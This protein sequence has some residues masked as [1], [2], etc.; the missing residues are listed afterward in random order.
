[1]PGDATAPGDC[2]DG[3]SA[4]PL[5]FSPTEPLASV[6]E[7]SGAVAMKDAAAFIA[8]AMEVEATLPPTLR[9]EPDVAPATDAAAATLA[10]QGTLGGGD[11][12]P[13]GS[14][15]VTPA[16]FA[17]APV[18]DTPTTGPEPDGG[19]GGGGDLE[20]TPAPVDTAVTPTGAGGGVKRLRL[21]H[22]DH[23][24]R[25]ALMSYVTEQGLVRLPRGCATSAPEACVGHCC[26]IYWTGD[27]EWYDADVQVYDER[28][29]LHF[30]WY[31]L[32][33][34]TEWIDLGAEEREGRIQWLPYNVDPDEWPPP[35]PPPPPPP[36]PPLPPRPGVGSGFGGKPSA[37]GTRAATPTP[38]VSAAASPSSM[39]YG[40]DA[41]ASAAAAVLN[42]V[43]DEEAEEE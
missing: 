27:S 19:G 20:S 5:P 12:A 9:P 24:T 37:S 35:P 40:M 18:L 17:A 34:A 29:G 11:A 25:R 39:V 13:A 43:G 23:V 16:P 31:H 2:G 6:A 28:T 32:D 1:F 8:E 10:V 41:L 33:E 38:A 14:R 26:R 3:G 7:P 21:F 15:D 30:L 22:L 42:E 4:A 36:R